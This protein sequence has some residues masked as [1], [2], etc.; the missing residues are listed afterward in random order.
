MRRLSSTPSGLYHVGGLPRANSEWTRCSSGVIAS[1][2]ER[3]N[4]MQSLPLLMAMPRREVHTSLSVWFCGLASRKHI[5]PNNLGRTTKASGILGRVKRIEYGFFPAEIPAIE[6][7]VKKYHP[8]PAATGLPHFKFQ[9]K[10]C[11][12][13]F[14]VSW[15]Q[16]S[17]FGYA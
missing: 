16:I 17:R 4:A 7:A 14:Y 11:S 2:D 15:R 13:R 12:N 8:M 6:F 9:A 1:L 5:S 10:H 3:T